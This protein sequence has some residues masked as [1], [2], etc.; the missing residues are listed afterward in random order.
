M[1]AA[2]S[3]ARA[4]PEQIVVVGPREAI[5]TKALWRAAHQRYRPFTTVLLLEPGERQRRLA[6][7]LPWIATMTTRD[8]Q[9]AAYVCRNF[10]CEAPVISARGVE[11]SGSVDVD[12]WVRGTHHATTHR[13]TS[14]PLP[15]DAWTETDVR[16]LLSE[17]LLAHR[18]RKESWW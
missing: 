1:S 4:E 11:M 6:E 10:T 18:A 7:R 14:V 16:Q 3:M 2:L 5:E 12:V 15:A 13:I 8:G 17:M 9:P